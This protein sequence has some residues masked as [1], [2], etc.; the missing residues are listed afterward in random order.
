MFWSTKTLGDRLPS[1]ITPFDQGRLENS[2]YTLR[3][4]SEVYISPTSK[5]RDGL[6]QT[7]L[8]LDS[9]QQFRIPPGQFAFLLTEE[10]VEVPSN[11]LAFI[12]LRAKYKFLGLVNISGFHVD[13]GYKGRL[14]F[15]V[16]NAGPSSISL[17]QGEE[18]FHLWYANLD[19]DSDCPIK[20]GHDHIP[21]GL[22]N[23]IG[24]QLLSLEGMSERV[25]KVEH[26]LVMWRTVGV[27][28]GAL[29]VSMLAV[30][31]RLCV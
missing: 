31:L 6:D 17:E 22:I 23:N 27:F 18:C 11:A 13:P 25:R 7:K 8:K 16:F 26:E 29:V 9:K 1:L 30:I 21:A 4:G 20:Q 12:S 28:I 14:I 15:A 10:A 3:I 19:Q 24:D 5:P 2:N